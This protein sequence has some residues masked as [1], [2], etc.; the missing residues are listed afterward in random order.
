VLALPLTLLVTTAVVAAAAEAP[1]IS[2]PGPAPST[3]P[4]IPPLPPAQFDNGLSIGGDDVKA[5]KQ[6]TR[7]SVDVHVNGQGPYKFIV[8]S[9]ADTSALGIKIAHDLQLPL[10]TPAVLNGMTSRNTVDRVK[11]NELTLGPSTVHDLDLPAL[12]EDDLGGDGLIGIDAL[13]QQRLLMDF[14]NK[15]IKIEDARKPVKSNPG[16]IVI[17][18]RRQK[19]QLILTEVRAAGFQLDAVVDT[20]TEITIG[21]MALRDKL[22]RKG[23]GR[24]WTVPVI[25]VT[26]VT[27]NLQLANIPE[28]VLGPITLHD[29]P[30]AFAD[31][32][33]FKAFGLDQQPSLLLGTDI[34]ETFRKISLDFRARKVRFQLKRCDARVVIST[35][36]ENLASRLT[37]NAGQEV[38]GSYG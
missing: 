33:P 13:V 7:L 12:K 23:R 22:I 15:I 9:G 6:E 11:V 34:L 3:P 21:N 14:E 18:A 5:K 17:V 16:D 35:S 32:P 28:L 26:G 8:D 30:I 1:K 36:P 37:S 4:D 2:K 31:V 29:V 27:V 24:F 10:S 20:G 19:G 25:G 38:C